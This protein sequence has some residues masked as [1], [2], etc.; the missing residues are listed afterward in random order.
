MA[1]RML[2]VLLGALL[3]RPAPPFTVFVADPLV[4]VRPKD[5]PRPA[6]EARLKAALNEVESFQIVIRAGEAVMKD[7]TAE[8][9]DL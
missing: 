9:S 2:F 5:P 3:V 8:A 1:A 4:R 6:K 7:V